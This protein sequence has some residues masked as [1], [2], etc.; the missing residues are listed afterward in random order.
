MHCQ[1]APNIESSAC[2]ARAAR[3]TCGEALMLSHVRE[4]RAP[5]PTGQRRQKST[6]PQRAR[7]SRRH[8]AGCRE[9]PKDMFNHALKKLFSGAFEGAS[10]LYL[11]CCTHSGAGEHKHRLGTI[12]RSCAESQLLNYCHDITGQSYA[13]ELASA[14]GNASTTQTE[15]QDTNKTPTNI[16]LSEH[17]YYMQHADTEIKCIALA[18]NT[19]HPTHVTSTSNTPKGTTYC[20]MRTAYTAIHSKLLQSM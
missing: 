18:N 1:G 5:G 14:P 3:T 20:T 2:L 8:H 19:H 4:T 16:C 12:V 17:V 15:P 6:G 11:F 10:S 13:D 9:S 7:R